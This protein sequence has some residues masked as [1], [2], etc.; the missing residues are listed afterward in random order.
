MLTIRRAQQEDCDSIARV[1]SAAVTGIR[2]TMYTAE[3]LQSWGTPKKAESYQESIRT[4]EFF[5]ADDDGVVMGFA[6]LKPE[7]GEVEA[8]YVSP[9]AGRRGVGLALLRKLDER[10]RAH[11]LSVIH[12]YSSLNAVPFYKRAGYVAQEQSKYR[13]STGVEIAC[14]PMTK[15]IT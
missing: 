7:N 3:E 1:H 6:I 12:L 5:V 13:L 2:T 8:V 10:A 14:V 11:S 15:T 9:K 4:K